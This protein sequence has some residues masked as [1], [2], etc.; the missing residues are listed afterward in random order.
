VLQ[1]LSLLFILYRYENDFSVN[2]VPTYFYIFLASIFAYFL[3][4]NFILNFF[5]KFA[6]FIQS[7]LFFYS[8]LIISNPFSMN[9][10]ITKKIFETETKLVPFDIVYLGNATQATFS[11]FEDDKSKKLLLKTV[12]SDDSIDDSPNLT[13]DLTD[14]DVAYLKKALRSSKLY[15]L[16]DINVSSKLKLSMDLF[17][18][19][20]R[21]IARHNSS[22]YQSCEFLNS[23]NLVQDENHLLLKKL[24]PQSGSIDRISVDEKI[25]KSNEKQKITIPCLGR[26]NE[27]PALHYLLRRL[28]YKLLETTLLS[29]KNIL[30]KVDI[31]AYKL[32]HSFSYE[33][34]QADLSI[35]KYSQQLKN[36]DYLKFSTPKHVI[37][38]S[39][40]F[41]ISEKKFLRKIFVDLYSSP[42]L[43]RNIPID[44]SLFFPQFE[45][46][47]TSL[48]SK[49]S[50]TCKDIEKSNIY[51]DFVSIK[52]SIDECHRIFKKDFI[53]LCQKVL[54]SPNEDI[55]WPSYSNCRDKKP[56]QMSDFKNIPKEV[57][58]KCNPSKL[59]S[60]FRFTCIDRNSK[61]SNT[62]SKNVTYKTINL[63][64]T[65]DSF[66]YFLAMKEVAQ[67][68]KPTLSYLSPLSL[69]SYS[70]LDSILKDNPI[71]GLA[72]LETS[73]PFEED[74]WI[75]SKKQYFGL[76]YTKSIESSFIEMFRNYQ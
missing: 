47:K 66:S 22:S 63:S 51:S 14:K 5:L 15:R 55:P 62:T 9:S 69:K 39:D 35:D 40:S 76:I 28:K 64:R 50:F 17:K 23:K 30:L 54:F 27:E 38:F 41:D 2:Q 71:L 42:I 33:E 72:L 37:M 73:N 45:F 20:D 13:I 25:K 34:F 52:N 65:I 36:K 44:D 4:T 74:D 75:Y 24:F 67:G 29:Y 18:N 12:L 32:S 3:A 61:N 60:S 59:K 21:N 31:L 57:E 11:I 46:K 1:V 16:R 19:V 49:E 43:G 48:S 58:L 10:S 68:L 7:I 56:W 70:R 8:L 53:D 26:R 6:F